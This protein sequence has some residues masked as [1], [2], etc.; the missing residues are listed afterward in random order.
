MGAPFREMRKVPSSSVRL[1]AWALTA[2]K[3]TDSAGQQRD[4]GYGQGAE[5]HA[6]HAT[7]VAGGGSSTSR[8][9]E[10]WGNENPVADSR[11]NPLVDPFSLR[12]GRETWAADGTWASL[13]NAQ[14]AAAVSS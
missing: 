2:D 8:L 6:A 7:H 11:P 5:S 4:L 13:W 10:R 9:V 1:S 14:P 3:G 12:G